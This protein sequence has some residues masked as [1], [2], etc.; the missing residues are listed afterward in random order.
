M[1]EG[2][3]PNTAKNNNNG[4][5][6]EQNE[7][8]YSRL[9]SRNMKIT[10][11]PEMMERVLAL[12]EQNVKDG[13]FPYAGLLEHNGVIIAEAVNTIPFPNSQ[14]DLPIFEPPDAH[15]ES[16]LAKEATRI[17]KER[18]PNSHAQQVAFL[19]GITTYANCDPCNMCSQALGGALV[20]K[21]VFAIPHKAAMETSKVDNP[22]L[23]TTE[24]V[25]QSMGLDLQIIGPVETARA[26]R[27]FK[28]G[29]DR[30]LKVFDEK[31]SR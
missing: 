4:I 21:V 5:G 25:Y 16:A 6:A 18:Y 27:V 2:I 29:W 1:I 13:R 10:F 22:I 15:P 31:P 19:Q 11:R 23:N 28:A 12:A 3:N 26:L 17:A 24:K 8:V 7:T 30:V 14:S 20:T 9:P